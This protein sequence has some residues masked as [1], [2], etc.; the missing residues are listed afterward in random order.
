MYISLP[1]IKNIL[2]N[3]YTY[4]EV[5]LSPD[6]IF[7]LPFSEYVLHFNHIYAFEKG[8]PSV[9]II[10]VPLFLFSIPEL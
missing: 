4:R 5:S 1:S 6:I 7:R 9:T 3:P 2:K 10:V 8:L